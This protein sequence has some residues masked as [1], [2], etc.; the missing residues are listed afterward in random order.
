MRWVLL[1]LSAVQKRRLRE[2]DGVFP[3][4]ADPQRRRADDD[5]LQVHQVQSGLAGELRPGTGE[6]QQNTQ[7][8]RRRSG[9]GEAHCR[10]TGG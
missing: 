10:R 5:L 6:S 7:H 3:P 4:G 2:H 9:G 8:W 1:F